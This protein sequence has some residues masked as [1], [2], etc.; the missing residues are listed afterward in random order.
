[1]AKEAEISAEES[2]E[3]EESVVMEEA[4]NAEVEANPLD[5]LDMGFKLD[6]EQQAALEFDPFKE[7]MPGD[8]KPEPAKE[9]KA[10]E[11]SEKPAADAAA[12]ETTE[13]PS[14][15]PRPGD[16]EPTP[17]TPAA[18]TVDLKDQQIADLT[19]TI[20]NLTEQVG[21][22]QKPVEATGSG[23]DDGAR[24]YREIPEPMMELINSEEPGERKQGIA[25]LVQGVGM[26]VHQEIMKDLETRLQ[27]AQSETQDGISRNAAL[28]ETYKDFYSA[29]PKLDDDAFRPMVAA[30]SAAVFKELGTT[31][32]S[33]AVRDAI[34]T[35]VINKLAGFSPTA[36]AAESVGN[37]NGAGSPPAE[38]TPATL[39]GG[40]SRPAS[41]AG[42]GSE[43]EIE[44]V[45]FGPGR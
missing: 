3:A 1:M 17:A 13:E 38:P 35:R 11:D 23:V 15:D 34:G 31:E 26:M 18:P 33:S 4:E 28:Q 20:S 8:P 30:E 32:W 27:A 37:G 16:Q 24:F 39:K 40:G 29:F 42:T 41:T 10:A 9:D 43:T 12:A 25:S 2:K 36:P 14:P 7:G 19:S 21:K 5:T 44:D 6:A 45:I 22:M